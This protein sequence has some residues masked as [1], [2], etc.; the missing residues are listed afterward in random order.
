MPVDATRL[1]TALDDLLVAAVACLDDPPD[2]RYVSHGQPAVDCE[3]LTVHA[4]GVRSV[5]LEQPADL[6]VPAGQPRVRV[7]TAVVT[8]WRAVCSA[9]DPT[10]EQLNVDGRRL[11]VDGW[12]LFAGLLQR[13]AVGDIWT[14]TSPLPKA[15]NVLLAEAPDVAGGYG[16]WTVTVDLAL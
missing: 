11:A 14:G 8:I 15:G 1:R 16:G 9:M 2:R 4:A 3:L 12:A 7:V 5:A 6:P 10:A 13:T